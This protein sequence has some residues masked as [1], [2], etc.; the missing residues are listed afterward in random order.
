MNSGLLLS[1]HSGASPKV[2]AAPPCVPG[3][4]V[5]IGGGSIGPRIRARRLEDA[6]GEAPTLQTADRKVKDSAGASVP[7]SGDNRTS[8]VAAIICGAVDAPLIV[9]SYGHRFPDSPQF[10]HDGEDLRKNRKKLPPD[11]ARARGPVPQ[12]CLQSIRDRPRAD[13]QVRTWA[14]GS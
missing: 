14:P 3:T 5:P 7:R 11:G 12:G 9:V 8:Y 6:D 2:S 13:Q 1:G 4:G 10:R